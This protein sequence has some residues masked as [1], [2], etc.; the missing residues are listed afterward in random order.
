MYQMQFCEI[1]LNSSVQQCDKQRLSKQAIQIWN[2]LK[3]GRKVSTGE[4]AAIA[5]QY[6]ARI[7]E[8]RKAIETVGLKIDL[9]ERGDNG[10]NFY[11]LKG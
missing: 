10:N 1:P 4:L 7:Y 3:T 6:N 9:V 5:C 8:I 2:L 11:Q